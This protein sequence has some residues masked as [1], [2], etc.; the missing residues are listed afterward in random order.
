MRDERR[1]AEVIG[2]DEDVV[3]RLDRREAV[4][5]HFE[6]ERAVPVGEDVVGRGADLGSPRHC[7]AAGNARLLEEDA[8]EE[9]VRHGAAAPDGRRQRVLKQADA[10]RVDAWVAEQAGEGAHEHGGAR[11]RLDVE[12]DQ[13]IAVALV[14]VE[15]LACEDAAVGGGASSERKGGAAGI[16][17]RQPHHLG[18]DIDEQ[19]LGEA[20]GARRRQCRAPPQRDAAQTSPS[21]EGS[22][23]RRREALR[24][25]AGDGRR[26]SRAIAPRR[27]AL[28]EARQ[29]SGE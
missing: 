18:A 14:L 20:T 9:I 5:R 7:Q 28:R 29:D 1:A 4:R 26:P 25:R 17:G 24:A 8:L 11:V 2:V 10:C 16:D 23:W 22:A 19:H 12:H 3:M 21:M 13:E 27:G 6:I 15:I